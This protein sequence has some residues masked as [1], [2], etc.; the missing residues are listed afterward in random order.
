MTA[1][2]WLA[3]IALLLFLPAGG[4][5]DTGSASDNDKRGVFYGGVSTGGARP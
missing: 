3:I 1:R 4:C 2:T 5:A